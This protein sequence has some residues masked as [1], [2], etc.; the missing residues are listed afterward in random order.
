MG[1]KPHD[2][3]FK[4]AKI[5]EAHGYRYAC[6]EFKITLDV[7]RECVKEIKD[8][9]QKFKKSVEG[10]GFRSL[11]YY[12]YRAACAIGIGDLKEDFFSWML[13]KRLEGMAGSIEQFAMAF[14]AIEVGAVSVS[15]SADDFR[16]AMR[17]AEPIGEIH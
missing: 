8:R 9:I 1:S 11:R 5:V 6:I 2:Q 4:I 14:A 17:Y 10:D 16:H 3:A 13:L 15:G 7:A 12:A